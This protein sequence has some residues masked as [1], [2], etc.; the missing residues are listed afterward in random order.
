MCRQAAV[1]VFAVN[2]IDT[3]RVRRI[4][5]TYSPIRRRSPALRFHQAIIRVLVTASQIDPSLLPFL[6]ATNAS[7]EA[8]A[9]A[10]SASAQSEE[11]A[12]N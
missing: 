9:L 4:T 11:P 6:D 7:E 1:P 10:R 8:A 12:R 2:A 3:A 5:F